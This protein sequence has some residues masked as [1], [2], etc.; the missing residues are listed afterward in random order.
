MSDQLRRSSSLRCASWDFY[1]DAD[2]PGTSPSDES[3]LEGGYRRGS[4]GLVVRSHQNVAPLTAA[5][6][7][8]VGGADNATFSS[9]PDEEASLGRCGSG[10]LVV[11][12]HRS[13][14][15][16]STQVMM[17]V[18]SPPLRCPHETCNLWNIWNS[19]FR[20]QFVISLSSCQ[21]LTVFL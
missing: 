16:L 5:L 20:I 13:I 1:D 6:G 8:G 12:S 19:A 17:L 21:A 7:V 2:V 15:P 9:N 3:E 10:G 14:A 4:G 11:R 18:V